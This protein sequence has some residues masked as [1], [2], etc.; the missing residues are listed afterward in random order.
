MKRM[1]ILAAVLAAALLTPVMLAQNG[2]T[3]ADKDIRAKIKAAALD[4]AMGYYTADEARMEKAV[5]HDLAK[6]IVR[7]DQ[8]GRDRVDHM[9][10]LRLI[11]ITKRG[12]GRQTPQKD[13]QADVEILDIYANTAMVKLE[14]RGWFDYLQVGRINGEWKIINVLWVVK[15]PQK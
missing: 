15:P 8:R 6:R 12:G 4:Y 9:T 2:D 11:Q 13:R 7:T 14:M 5:F 10:A 3:E 1:K